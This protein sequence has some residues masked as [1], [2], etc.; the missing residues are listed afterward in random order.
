MQAN[1]AESYWGCS[2]REC[3]ECIRAVPTKEPRAAFLS[4]PSI[5]GWMRDGPRTINTEAKC[6]GGGGG[7]ESEKKPRQVQSRRCAAVI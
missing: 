7:K 4:T 3:T 2:E 1:V 6:V 5:R